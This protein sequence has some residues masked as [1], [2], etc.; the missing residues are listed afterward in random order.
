MKRQNALGMKMQGMQSVLQQAIMS[1]MRV[2]HQIA[3]AQIS[4]THRSQSERMSTFLFAA[5]VAIKCTNF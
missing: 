1:N 2:P 3:S 5:R 4:A